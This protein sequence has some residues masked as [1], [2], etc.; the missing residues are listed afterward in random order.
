MQGFVERFLFAALGGV[1]NRSGWSL[2][3]IRKRGNLIVAR[4]PMT[5]GLAT[6][7]GS[8]RT[9]TLDLNRKFLRLQDRR[10]WLVR[11][12][13]VLTFDQIAGI[14]YG[15]VDLNKLSSVLPFNSYQE[16]DIFEV[17]LTLKNQESVLLFQFRGAGSWDN[18]GPL[19]DW[20]YLGDQMEAELA[21]GGQEQV[22]RIFA[23]V[24]SSR[25]G[26]PLS[27]VPS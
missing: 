17:G 11:W 5:L 20:M 4:S 13:R 22:S 8:A 23:E 18:S 14:E 10:L 19:P 26:V 1:I 25:I 3:R 7:G 15:Y 24:L 12:S 9:L 27:G 2:P 21:A 6:L 16:H